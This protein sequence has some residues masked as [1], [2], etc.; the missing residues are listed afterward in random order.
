[1][2]EA[3]KRLP[4]IQEEKGRATIGAA[5]TLLGKVYL[6]LKQYQEAVE[7]LHNVKGYALVKNY[8]QIFG[9]DNEYNEESIF[10]VN[11]TSNLENEGSA[12]V[13]CLHLQAK[14]RHWVLWEL[15]TTR[16][17]RHKNCT[18]YILQMTSARM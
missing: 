1:M 13:I 11:F 5:Y 6:T 8:S 2:K 4:A 16:I 9:P 17:Y 14:V 18:I 3:I 12:W 10:E 15:Y 7:A